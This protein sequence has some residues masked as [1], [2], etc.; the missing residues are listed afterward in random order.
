MK[1]KRR[2]SLKTSELERALNGLERA[3]KSV[4][5]ILDSGF[6]EGDPVPTTD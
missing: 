2:H 5:A 1:A 4:R 6:E 3:R